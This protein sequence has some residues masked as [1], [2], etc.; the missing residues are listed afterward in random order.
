MLHRYLKRLDVAQPPWVLESEWAGL[1]NTLQQWK[2][3]LPPD[4]DFSPIAICTRKEASQLGELC[5]LHCTYHQTLVNLYR[6]GWPDLYRFRSPVYFPPE[7][8]EFLHHIQERCFAHTKEVIS[9][10]QETSKHGLWMLS[11]SWIVVLLHENLRGML[12]HAKLVARRG[13]DAAPVWSQVVPNAQFCVETLRS[14]RAMFATAKPCY[15]SAIRMAKEA[16]LGRYTAEPDGDRM[17]TDVSRVEGTGEPPPPNTPHQESLD[18]SLNPLSIY[19]LA[20]EGVSEKH[21]AES[22]VSPQSPINTLS[23]T[24]IQLPTCG[25]SASAV[26]RLDGMQQHM[27]WL[28][29]DAGEM[30]HGFA[31]MDW[32][33]LWRPMDL[34]SDGIGPLLPASIPHFGEEGLDSLIGDPSFW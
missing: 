22:H 19:R 32:N 26:T 15:L 6:I 8:Q 12:H 25:E 18:Y 14:M 31:P 20:R 21:A 27:D 9:I 16:G 5:L 1:L 34:S 29:R 23:D 3:N 4:L 30:D 17:D 10:L 2:S 33:V 24:S 28:Q 13:E 11:D 7:Q